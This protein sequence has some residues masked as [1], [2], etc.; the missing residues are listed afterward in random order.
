MASSVSSS[1]GKD[2]TSKGKT[3]RGHYGNY[4]SQP[5]AKIPKTTFYR[6]L[7][8]SK[9][10][11][12][13]DQE[14]LSSV[15]KG[16]DDEVI[17]LSNHPVQLSSFLN[18]SAE[19][20]DDSGDPT[21]SQG[22]R[23]ISQTGLSRSVEVEQP[24]DREELDFKAANTTL[25][26]AQASIVDDI[27]PW[28][29]PDV[30]DP[31]ID[32]EQRQMNFAFPSHEEN[33]LDDIWSVEE[34]FET[35]DESSTETSQETDG[36]SLPLF[37]GA[38]LTLGASMLLVITFAMRHSITGVALSDL[39]LL[40]EV[41]L[42]SPNCFGHS[43]KLIRNF[44]KQLKNPIEY[45]FYCSFCFEYIG[46]NKSHSGHC[47]NKH[48]LQDFTKKGSLAYF[49]IIPFITQLQALLASKYKLHKCC[50]CHYYLS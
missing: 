9:S 42:I 1:S 40:I 15:M 38:R 48:C 45:H 21:C 18:E 27:T 36:S 12:D 8:K 13:N 26:E 32:M 44:F 24:T 7:N 50:Y 14:T 41:H 4:L 49:I 23:T 16:M 35:S 43:M 10:A 37:E 20:L 6:M 17:K 19:I 47:P 22:A 2:T 30:D 39:L 31:A 25:D 11:E 5:N 28:N 29:F 3:K 46:V 34:E 33:I